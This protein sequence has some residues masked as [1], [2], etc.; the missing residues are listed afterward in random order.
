MSL[1]DK[2]QP[3]LL[4]I[5]D[6]FLT[7][8]NFKR[9]VIVLSETQDKGFVGFILNRPLNLQLADA[10]PEFK[11]IDAPLYYG[12]PVQTD[13]MH[14]F[15]TLGHEIKDSIEVVDGVFWGG[16]FDQVRELI[17][18]KKVDPKEFR[19]FLGYAGWDKTQLVDELKNKSWI[20][21]QTKF[22]HMFEEDPNALWKGSLKEKGGKFS[23][24]ANFPDDPI[25]N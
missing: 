12:G 20:L 15:H 10:I 8:P 5:A 19:F 21:H 2:I 17:I 3:G 7:D 25:L 1:K 16:D 6:P 18:D 23:L 14:F 4:L 13:T 22:K 11:D 24:I 9:T